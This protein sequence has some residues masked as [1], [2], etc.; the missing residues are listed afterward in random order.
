MLKDILEVRPLDG[1]RLWLRFE[2][3]V[4][5]RVDLAEL[6]RFDGVFA[7]LADRDKFLEVAVVKDSGTIGWPW[8]ADLDPDVLYA[9]IT[10][11]PISQLNDA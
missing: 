4:E 6:I 9:K 8:G 1:H 3:G 5:G 7:P 10:K 11:Q 2:D